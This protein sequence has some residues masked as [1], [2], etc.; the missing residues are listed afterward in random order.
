M[1]H[2]IGKDGFLWWIGVVEATDDPL[3]LGRCRVRCFGYHPKRI[4]TSTPNEQPVPPDH[5]PWAT[6]LMP[7]NLQNFHGRP[8]AGD[9]VIG[10]FLDAQDAQE[11]VILG[12][13]PGIPTVVNDYFSMHPRFAKTFTK[14]K[15]DETTNRSQLINTLHSLVDK[16]TKQLVTLPEE[17]VYLS[18]TDISSVKTKLTNSEARTDQTFAFYH[19]NGSKIEIGDSANLQKQ[20]INKAL[21]QL[22]NGSSLEIRKEVLNESGDSTD[23]VTLNHS[24]SSGK[25]ELKTNVVS[26]ITT[27]S[28]TLVSPAADILIKKV[29]E[30]KNTFSIT[31]SGAEVKITKEG[32]DTTLNITHPKGTSITI[33]PEG[34]ITIN[35]PKTVTISSS[36]VMNIAGTS[37]NLNSPVTNN[38][39]VLNT[40][41]LNAETINLAGVGNLASKIAAMDLEIAVAK[42]LPVPSP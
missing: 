12:I 7:S 15:N 17:G 28:L 33:S 23:Y 27:D 5:L 40:L 26:G 21:L 11:P 38:Q 13:L 36:E 3:Q 31:S 2:Y 9:W 10:F 41:V 8:N 32:A 20:G 25:I 30:D 16:E 1:N 34:Q 29:G 14:I 24:A 18:N 19:K 22:S 42:T 35:S 37:I 6:C 39:S 4:S